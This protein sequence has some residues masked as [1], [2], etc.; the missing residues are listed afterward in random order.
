MHGEVRK[1][2]NRY[3]KRMGIETKD[4]ARLLRKRARRNKKLGLREKESPD[5]ISQTGYSDPTAFCAIND[6]K[7]R[8]PGTKKPDLDLV[9]NSTPNLGKTPDGIK[10]I[11]LQGGSVNPK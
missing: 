7:Y 5:F 1:L 6:I 4:E 9:S 10:M 11:V 3:F 2:E 8:K